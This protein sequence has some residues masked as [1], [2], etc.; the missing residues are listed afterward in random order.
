MRILIAADAP[1]DPDSGAAG[2]T[3]QVSNELKKLGYEVDNIWANDLPHKIK[4]WNLH[5]LLELPNAYV[6]VIKNKLKQRKKY[7]VI[8]ISQPHCFLAAKYARK[9]L[10]NTILIHRSHGLELNAERALKPFIEKEKA[11]IRSYG[12]KMLSRAMSFLLERHSH[13]AFKY[14]DGHIVASEQDRE[15]L[16]GE[17]HVDPERIKVIVEGVPDLFINTPVKPLTPDRHKKLLFIGQFAFFKAPHILANIINQ[18]LKLKSD[19]VMTWVCDQEHHNHVRELL[20]PKIQERVNLLPWMSQEKLIP[21][22]DEHGIFLL[23]TLFEGSA[24]VH[25]EAMARGLCVISSKVAAMRDTIK[26]GENGFLVRAGAAN[27]FTNRTLELLEDFALAKSVSQKA[28]ITAQR[29]S[30]K[31]NVKESVE[32]YTK[33]LEKK[34]KVNE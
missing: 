2:T 32:F 31:D 23:T 11:D 7:D 17:F 12:R 19:I 14:C 24:K 18:V 15:F 9:H 26:N 20:D 5:Y 6:G 34:K 3:Y 25:L 16:I 4:H 29:C 10:P 22:Y 1:C 33:L 8:Q 21:V 30:C 27:E 13:L 28:I